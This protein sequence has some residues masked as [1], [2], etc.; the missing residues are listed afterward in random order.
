MFWKR[1][2]ESKQKIVRYAFTTS[3]LAEMDIPMLNGSMC[4]SYL[5]FWCKLGR[6]DERLMIKYWLSDWAKHHRNEIAMQCQSYHK[7]GLL[8]AIWEWLGLFNVSTNLIFAVHTGQLFRCDSCLTVIC[9]SPTVLYMQ[10]P[11]SF[12]SIGGARSW[13]M[14]NAIKF[15]LW[16]TWYFNTQILC[17]NAVKI[18]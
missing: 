7:T 10:K 6:R 17:A 5:R 1:K 18:K 15:H 13:K 14:S 4:C 8:K 2:K 11:S 3:L 9:E 12:C 16:M